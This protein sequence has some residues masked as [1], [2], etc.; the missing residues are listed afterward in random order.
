MLWI[1]NKTRE[2]FLLILAL[3]FVLLFAPLM[4]FWR[5][6]FGAW[7]LNTYSTIHGPHAFDWGG[8]HVLNVLFSSNRGLFI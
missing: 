1:K 7:L 6:V 8:H 4:I 5:V 2:P 3:I